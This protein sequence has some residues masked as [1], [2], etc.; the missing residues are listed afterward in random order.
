VAQVAQGGGAVTILGD[1]EEL[2][3]CGTEGRGQ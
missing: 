1:V 3:G 2:R